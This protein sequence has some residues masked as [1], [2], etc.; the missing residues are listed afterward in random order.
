M[1]I[2]KIELLDKVSPGILLYLQANPHLGGGHCPFL[3]HQK[4]DREDSVVTEVD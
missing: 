2:L 4:E 1:A 3:L